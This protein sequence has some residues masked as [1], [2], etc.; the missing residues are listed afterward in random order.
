MYVAQADRLPSVKIVAR[1][2]AGVIL[3]L[4][5]CCPMGAKG[6]EVVLTKDLT[7][8]IVG[9]AW[10]KREAFTDGLPDPVRSDSLVKCKKHELPK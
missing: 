2:S 5:A 4:V 9:T 1:M 3:I 7:E 10:K 8:L 6:A